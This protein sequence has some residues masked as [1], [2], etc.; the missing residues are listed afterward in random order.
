MR[1]V[2]SELNCVLYTDSIHIIGERA[3][4][5]YPCRRIRRLEQNWVGQKE[6]PAGRYFS[7]GTRLRARLKARKNWR[8]CSGVP[9]VTRKA[10]GAPH[11]PFMGRT[12]TPSACKAWHSRAESSPRSQNRK[13]AQVGTTRIPSSAI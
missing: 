7:S 12:M 8:F 2:R 1:N 5:E 13:L 11:G 3:S 6:G 9:M 4:F 10:L